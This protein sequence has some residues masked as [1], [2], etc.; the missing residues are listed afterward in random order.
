MSG[1]TITPA[2]VRGAGS[3]VTPRPAD[4][5]DGGLYR[6]TREAYQRAAAA[7]LFDD[8]R[9][10]LLD[11]EIW[12]MPPQLTPHA[13]AIRRTFSAL[14]KVFGDGFDVSM[15]LPVTISNWSEPEPDVTVARGTAED[16]ADH[17]PG[18]AEI[19]LLVEVSDS[20]LR[21]DQSRKARAYA[22]AGITDYWIVSLVDGRLE[23]YRDPTPEGVYQ[24]VTAC[25]PQAALS[26]SAQ[27][28]VEIRVA[29]LLPPMSQP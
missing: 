14:R 11:G 3:S 26:S 25:D 6:W 29:D 2:T 9:V 24:S 16:F 22:Q 28:D 19:A 20:T 12:I 1:A 21:K 15:Q 7:G 5:A 18:P 10:E 27:P 23:V 8:K 13:T 4:G 17:H